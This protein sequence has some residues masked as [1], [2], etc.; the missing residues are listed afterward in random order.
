M[1]HSHHGREENL[2]YV[3]FFSHV[4]HAEIR[5]EVASLASLNECVQSLIDALGGIGRTVS[6]WVER[7]RN[8]QFCIEHCIQV[9]LR[10]LK[11]PIL[12]HK[13]VLIEIHFFEYHGLGRP[14]RLLSRAL[15]AGLSQM[16]GKACSS[17]ALA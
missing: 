4:S 3:Y 16:T 1:G 11:L 9:L 8:F 10:L 5:R 6:L 13:L 15:K 14:P 17:P 12:E 2:K 7:L